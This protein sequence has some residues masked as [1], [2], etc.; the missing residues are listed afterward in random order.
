MDEAETH[1]TIESSEQLENEVESIRGTIGQIASELD[2]RRRDLVNW[3]LQV[4]RHA[5][6]IVSAAAGVIVLLGAT[7]TLGAL[8]GRRR[9]SLFA[10]AGRLREAFARIMEHPER[11]ARRPPGIANQALAAAAASL[12][13]ALA[14]SAYDALMR[15]SPARTQPAA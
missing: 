1:V 4:R 8:R 12:S 7:A 10:K 15:R 14:H 2:Q 3:R 6:A 9:P 13:G 5:R 11:V